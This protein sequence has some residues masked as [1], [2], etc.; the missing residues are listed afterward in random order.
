MSEHTEQVALFRWSAMRANTIPALRML[1]AVPNGGAR[2]KATAGRLKAEG[3]RAGVPDVCL[4]VPSGIYASLWIEL[5][6]P[7]EPGKPK[8]VTSEAQRQW[9]GDLQAYGNCACVVYGWDE[10]RILIESYLRADS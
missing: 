7:Y 10:A 3:V 2:A 6:R 4:P 1:F 5:K 8:G 9:I